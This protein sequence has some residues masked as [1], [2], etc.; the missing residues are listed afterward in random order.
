MCLQNSSK[1][2]DED[3]LSYE[4]TLQRWDVDQWTNTR[5]EEMSTINR[6]NTF[7]L[8]PLPD[9]V[10]PLKSRWVNVVKQNQIGKPIQKEARLV[11]KGNKQKSGIDYGDVFAH[12]L[13]G[14]TVCFLFARATIF[15]WDIHSVDIVGTFLNGQV[16]ED[17]HMEHMPGFEDG[18][19][20]VLKLVG[21]VYGVQQSC[22]SLVRQTY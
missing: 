18:T 15:N 9:G 8:I 14:D 19:N 6:Y 16:Q 20:K 4:E 10:K 7:K 2:Y 17:I 13:H 5:N 12:V 3:D 11:V 1:S 21:N 22:T